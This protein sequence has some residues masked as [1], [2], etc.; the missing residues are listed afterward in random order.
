[1]IYEE[2]E[3]TEEQASL[4][5]AHTLHESPFHWVPS[6]SANTVHSCEHFYDISEGTFYHF[7][8]D[9]LDEKLL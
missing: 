5:L 9:H 6:L 4:L 8:P 7:N 2:D 1:M 3:Y